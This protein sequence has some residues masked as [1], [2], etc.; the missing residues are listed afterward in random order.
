MH[1]ALSAELSALRELVVTL[2]EALE[3]SRRENLLLRQKIDSLV[4]RMTLTLCQLSG[5]FFYAVQ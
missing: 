5:V 2:K 1:T 4:R 3:L